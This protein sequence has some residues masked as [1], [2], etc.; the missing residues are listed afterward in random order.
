MHNSVCFCFSFLLFAYKGSNSTTISISGNGSIQL[1][2]FEGKKKFVPDECLKKHS[3][4]ATQVH[5]P[6]FSPS[7]TLVSG[8]DDCRVILWNLS[9]A[10]CNGTSATEKNAKETSSVCVVHEVQHG[11]KINW[12]SSNLLT[13]N[14]FV[15]DLTND[16]SVYSVT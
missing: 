7:D 4:S 13:Q 6:K 8:G 5:F 11:S 14:I 1:I 3:S 12:I 16:I 10:K 2:R 15:S 9:S